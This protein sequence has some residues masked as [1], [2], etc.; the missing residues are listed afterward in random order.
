[1][2][3]MTDLLA[4][5]AEPKRHRLLGTQK[6][7]V[8]G[9]IRQ[10]SFDPE[11]FDWTERA[12]R[13]EEHLLIPVII[14]KP[15]DFYFE[16]DWSDDQSAHWAQYSPG[17]GVT[18]KRVLPGDWVSLY[19]HLE[20]WLSCLRTQIDAPDLWGTISGD[21]SLINLAASSDTSNARFTAE[22]QTTISKRLHQLK[23]DII[24]THRF[25]GQQAEFVRER[26]QYL[27]DATSRVGK[28]DW[29]MLAL[30]VII[31]IALTPNL[32]P[33]QAGAIFRKLASAIHH[34]LHG[35]LYLN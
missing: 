5:N 17:E 27:E 6:N 8:H 21:R 15:S 1:M 20:K 9:A 19:T 23:E 4:S 26:F 31:Q 30:S 22:E 18:E 10:R 2:G 29:L 7:D 14:H 25:L 13:V 35:I 32:Q 28:K 34:I 11:D 24:A 12:S 33:S 16:F 3:V